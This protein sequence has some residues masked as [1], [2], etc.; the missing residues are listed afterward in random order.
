[1]Y[2]FITFYKFYATVEGWLNKKEELIISKIILFSNNCPKCKILKQKLDQKQI[3]YEECNDVDIM[4]ENGFLSM[5][6]L[7]IDEEIMNYL[8]AVNWIKEI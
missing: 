8:N 6:M 2:K 1:M 7:K 5:P 4:I 3:T